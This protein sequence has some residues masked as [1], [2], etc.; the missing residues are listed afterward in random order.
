MQGILNKIIEF[1]TR[2]HGDQTRKYTPEPY[3]VHPVRVMRICEHFTKDVTV[4]SAAILH[5]V[6]EDT[7]IT[8]EE[9]SSFLRSVMNEHEA[10]KTLQ[11]VV[12]LTDVYIKKDYPQ[13][14][15]RKRKALE[16][17]RMEKTS[18]DAQTIKYADIIDN[19][20]EI[21][22][23]D[24]SFGRVFLYECKALLKR[25]TKGDPELYKKAMDTIEIN[26]KKLSAK[27]IPVKH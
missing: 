12:E 11:L 3:I 20:V 1:A 8:R 22:N 15:R 23:H 19:C 10:R 14:N 16:Q 26:L 7:P 24:R 6:L 27:E 4:L 25:M 9:M 21:I 17:D 5:D 2:A 18:P 13:W